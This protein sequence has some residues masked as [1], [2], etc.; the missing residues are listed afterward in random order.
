MGLNIL[1]LCTN[2]TNRITF[3]V[4]IHGTAASP[5]VRCMVGAEPALC[6]IATNIGGDAWE[7]LIKLPEE[8]PTG[9]QPFRVEVQLN[10]RLFTPIQR[11]ITVAA[12]EDVTPKITVSQVSE[13]EAAPVQP[14]APTPVIEPPKPRIDAVVVPRE[15]LPE[16]SPVKL[17]LAQ[18]IAALVPQIES[19]VQSKPKTALPKAPELSGLKGLTEGNVAPIAPAVNVEPS[20]EQ[21]KTLQE[22]A[23][24]AKDLI[25]SLS[26]VTEAAK[27]AAQIPKLS[28][29][30]APVLKGLSSFMIAAPVKIPPRMVAPIVEDITISIADVANEALDTVK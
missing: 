17:N 8:F 24:L 5:T 7:A 2:T 19:K 1:M 15:N 28:V 6:F 3:K 20:A 30:K 18:A 10:G 14:P 13:P 22:S 26:K 21:K 23:Q 27:P 4:D 29:P 11:E 9:V 25:N 16:T 12:K